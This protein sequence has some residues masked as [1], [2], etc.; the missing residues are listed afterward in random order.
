MSGSIVN[1]VDI[2]SLKTQSCKTVRYVIINQVFQKHTVVKLTKCSKASLSLEQWS[3]NSNKQTRRKSI[4][5]VSGRK[6]DYR[7]GAKKD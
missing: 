4:F 5:L 3:V 7:R 1:H 6:A 2:R